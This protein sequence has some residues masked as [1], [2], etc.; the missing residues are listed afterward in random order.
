MGGAHDPPAVDERSAV[1][2]L[3][4]VA[5]GAR[6]A[7][8]YRLEALIPDRF[9]HPRPSGN[10]ARVGQLW[11]A[12]DDVLAR[13]VAVLVV[14]ADD[15]MAAQVLAGARAAARVAHP[16]L[17]KV[18]DAGT[19]GDMDDAVFVVTEYFGGGSLE[20]ELRAHGPLDPL[21][22]VDLVADIAD[23][24]AAANAAGLQELAPTPG[25][26]LYTES[27]V[28]RFAGI[29][30]AAPPGQAAP[31]GAPE[32]AA[33]T[34]GEPLDDTPDRQRV[35]TVAL[36]RLLYAALTARWPGD[37]DTSALPAAP[38]RDGHLCTPRQVRGGVPREVD[39]AVA[40]ALDDPVLRRGLPSIESPAAFAAALAPLR[41]AALDA[42]PYG[43]DTAEIPAVDRG[44]GAT[45]RRLFP[46]RRRVRAG[47]VLAAAVVAV[48]VGGLFWTGPTLYAHFNN[49]P[50]TTPT[51][52][53]QQ[54]TP[55]PTQTTGAVLRPASAV[56]FDPYGDHSDP[57]VSEAPKAIDGDPST[58]WHTQ[59]FAT[60][61]LGN[62]KPGVG[63]L[64]DL[65][66]SR[67]V[68]SVHLRLLG[69]GT[70]VSLLTSDGGEPPRNEKSMTQV[71]TAR[72]AGSQVTLQGAAPTTGRYWVIWLTRLPSAD[73]GFAGGVA[74]ITFDS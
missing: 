7:E 2:G 38:L 23:A 19:A 74:E 66:A 43:A 69:D 21:P 63:L 25:R 33:G 65:G 71:A 28:P 42:H 46:A 11:R 31:G 15:P 6:V 47:V 3:P 27:G 18:Y 72:D 52:G 34:S 61:T 62:L 73:G 12:Y 1:S 39:L 13:P 54:P 26:V 37:D 44:P 49:H 57:H 55:T 51:T 70:T 56:E 29:A 24:V 50:A 22:A 35:E 14:E 17:A 10:A 36:A 58:A 8:R 45:A 59:T 64:I 30:L 68:A 60:A 20:E 40:R 53:D 9:P 5:P 67:K 48:A 4:A 32:S 16:M 41:S